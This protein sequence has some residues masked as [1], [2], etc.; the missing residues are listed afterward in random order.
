MSNIHVESFTNAF[1]PL[2][3]SMNRFS[4]ALLK[5]MEIL[6]DARK[7]IETALKNSIS[8]SPIAIDFYFFTV[9]LLQAIKDGT[10]DN[11][12]LASKTINSILNIRKSIHSIQDSLTMASISYA[13][14]THFEET[15]SFFIKVISL[16][17]PKNRKDYMNYKDIFAQSKLYKDMTSDTN[18]WLKVFEKLYEEKDN[19]ME[20]FSTL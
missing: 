14:G 17:I 9:A 10:K 8:H 2:A 16:W 7:H 11:E 3:Q 12:A 18:Y 15:K 6:P 1:N 4:K 19:S 13:Y 20:L 5:Y